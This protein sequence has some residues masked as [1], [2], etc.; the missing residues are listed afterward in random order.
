MRFIPR[1]VIIVKGSY[2]FHTKKKRSLSWAV[3]STLVCNYAGSILRPAG[4]TWSFI[5]WFLTTNSSL[6]SWVLPLANTRSTDIR[7]YSWNG[8]ASQESQKYLEIIAYCCWSKKARPALRHLACNNKHCLLDTKIFSGESRCYPLGGKPERWRDLCL[9]CW[10]QTPVWGVIISESPTSGIMCQIFR[11]KLT[12]CWHLRTRVG[13]KYNDLVLW[14][15]L[16]IDH[17]LLL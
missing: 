4:T 6:N 1:I 12:S 17:L 13:T 7:L 5:N 8:K 2:L 10:R 3:I 14:S 15:K 11:H 16:G 9:N